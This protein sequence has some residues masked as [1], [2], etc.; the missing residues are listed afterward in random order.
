M[1]I[2]IKN[3]QKAITNNSVFNDFLNDPTVSQHLVFIPKE[4]HSLGAALLNALS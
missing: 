3:Q 4:F 1:K 2:K